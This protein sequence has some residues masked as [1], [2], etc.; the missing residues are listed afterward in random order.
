MASRRSATAFAQRWTGTTIAWCV[1]SDLQPPE[2]ARVDDRI[3]SRFMKHVEF[4]DDGCW[5]WT[6][7]TIASK[8]CANRYGRF[9]YRLRATTAHRASHEMFIGPIPSGLT[10]D[11]LCQN[12]LC[13]NPAHLEAITSGANTL[14][15]P[16]TLAAQNS[17]KTHCK[18]GHELTEENTRLQ[19]RAGGARKSRTCRE[20]ERIKQRKREGRVWVECSGCGWENRR[21]ESRV[22]VAPCSKCGGEVRRSGRG[23]K[24]A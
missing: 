4:R 7:G 14:R 6:A 24:A 2:E 11:H 8:G 12:T 5:Q 16:A 17:L 21:E 1:M 20:C 10:V 18:R 15:S 23:R 22:S 19:F 9:W 13:V 3:M